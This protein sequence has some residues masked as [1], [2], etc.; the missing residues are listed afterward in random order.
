MKKNKKKSMLI[1]CW[2][3]DNGD[4][5]ISYIDRDD[6][7]IQQFIQRNAIAMQNKEFHKDADGYYNPDEV[8]CLIMKEFHDVYNK[9]QGRLSEFYFEVSKQGDSFHP[10]CLGFVDIFVSREDYRYYQSYDYS[11]SIIKKDWME[12][13]LKQLSVD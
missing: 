10:V 6:G 8:I 4:F 2:E 12:S 9:E 7:L 3:L 13:Y 5:A 11:C 1:M